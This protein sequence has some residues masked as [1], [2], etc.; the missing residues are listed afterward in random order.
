MMTEGDKVRAEIIETGDSKIKS[1]RIVINAPAWKVFDLLANPSRHKEIDGSNTIQNRI[2]GPERLSLGSKFGMAMHLGID[3]RITNTVVE[4][5]E[6]KLIA[7]R[8][9][10]GGCQDPSSPKRGH[11]SS[12]ETVGR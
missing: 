5:E 9:S 3:Y 11:G 8:H 10:N 6:N 1:A 2:S 7:W 4:F 12:L